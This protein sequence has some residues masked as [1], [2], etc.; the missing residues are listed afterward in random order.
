MKSDNKMTAGLNDNLRTNFANCPTAP[1]PILL[2][3]FFVLLF[4][5]AT[6]VVFYLCA[7]G[8]ESYNITNEIQ[9]VVMLVMGIFAGLIGFNVFKKLI[10]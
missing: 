3:Y 9:I 8:M 6:T 1:R 5:V 2:S 10:F 4:F 7:K